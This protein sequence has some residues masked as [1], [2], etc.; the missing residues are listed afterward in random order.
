M[1]YFYP[2]L[3]H[4]LLHSPP[5]FVCCKL[6]LL[7]HSARRYLSLCRIH[8]QLQW[9]RLI[10]CYSCSSFCI[11]H[12][13]ASRRSK[14]FLWCNE[15]TVQQNYVAWHIPLYWLISLKFW[16]LMCSKWNSHFYLRMF[17]LKD[18]KDCPLVSFQ[19]DFTAQC[20][21]GTGSCLCRKIFEC[22]RTL[23]E[24]NQQKFHWF[25]LLTFNCVC[26]WVSGSTCS[27][28]LL[29][30]IG[31]A[32]QT[33]SNATLDFS[34]RLYLIDLY[35]ASCWALCSNSNAQS[36]LYSFV[37]SKALL[38]SSRPSSSL[39]RLCL[40]DLRL[41]IWQ[42]AK[43]VYFWT[44]LWITHWVALVW[45]QWFSIYFPIST[46]SSTDE[47]VVPGWDKA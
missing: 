13:Y 46:Y 31:I 45:K 40:V 41:S 2:L 23:L 30:W 26:R 18:L 38:Y 19:S 3:D 34:L 43:S 21:W 12:K 17:G 14:D 39:R 20:S 22:N 24:S 7:C 33:C 36:K 27:V 32:D 37:F 44:K 4:P 8:S 1:Q 29:S 10:C 6:L 35:Q 11:T 25:L 9:S 42:N 15:R 28:D 16:S 5:V 47:W